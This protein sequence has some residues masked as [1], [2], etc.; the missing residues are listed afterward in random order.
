MQTASVKQVSQRPS[1]LKATTE[2][3][4]ESLQPITGY[5]NKPLVSVEKAVEP[6][7][8]IVPSIYERITE[9]RKH[10]RNTGDGVT[11][12]ESIA[13]KLYTMSWPPLEE[14]LYFALN[15]ALCSSDRRKLEPWFLY[16]RLFFNGL[17]RLPLVSDTIYRGVKKHLGK[18]Y[19]R[20]KKIIWWRFS[21]CT[22]A[23]HVLQEEQF[24]GKNGPRTMFIIKC[25][26]GRDISKHSHFSSEKEVLLLPETEFIITGELIEGDLRVIEMQE[27]GSKPREIVMTLNEPS[28]P[29]KKQFSLDLKNPLPILES[30]YSAVPFKAKGTSI[31]STL[32]TPIEETQ[33]SISIPQYRNSR[34]QE[35]IAD[36]RLSSELNLASMGLGDQDMR[37][38]AEDAIRWTTVCNDF[39]RMKIHEF[40]FGCS[41]R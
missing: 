26:S 12:D 23:L 32:I 31:V 2:E 21:S 9:A 17:L 3:D 6:L 11:E 34:L 7:I 38:V 39:M 8:D 10:C 19:E 5:E 20:E 13:I 1:Y 37:I 33:S 15:T 24:L 18:D 14:C 36:N 16:L 30:K 22:Q 27:I 41:S 28:L 29:S 40:L 35:T 4:N 25:Q